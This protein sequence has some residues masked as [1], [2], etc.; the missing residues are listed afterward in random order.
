[1]QMHVKPKQ[2]NSLK[3]NTRPLT[4]LMEGWMKLDQRG[5]DVGEL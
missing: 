5:K 2:T 1:M 3:I 4:N